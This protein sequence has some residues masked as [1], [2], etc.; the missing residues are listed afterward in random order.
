MAARIYAEAADYYRFLG[1]ADPEEA[2]PE[3]DALLVR[4]SNKVDRD[5]RFDV[6]ATD[7]DGM[8][9]DTEIIEAFRDATCA[10]AAWF[11]ETDDITG[12]DSQNGSVKIG[13]VSLGS[14][15]TQGN[16]R[17][18][19]DSRRSSEAIDILVTAGLCSA[20]ANHN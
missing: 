9:T 3:L 16:P 10:Y 8:P 1:Q 15:N 5:T 4:A 13:S 18:T 12:A 19:D 14:T 20:F 2:D 7:V 11:D 6:Y 17:T